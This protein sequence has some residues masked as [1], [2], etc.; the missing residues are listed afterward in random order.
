MAIIEAYAVP[1][2]PI[3]VA[4]VGR[5]QEQEA[6]S[7]LDAF[8]A[9]ARRIAALE[10]ELLIVST[11]HG[12]LYRDALTVSSGAGAWGDLGDFRCP[13]ERIDLRFDEDFVAALLTDAERSGLS[14]IARPVP[15]GALDH[16]VTVP[17]HFVGADLPKG[18]KAVRIGI[19]FEDERAHYE[20]GRCVARVAEATGR[21]TVYLASGDLSHRLKSDGPYGY[22]PSGPAF[23]K[24]MCA[25]FSSGDLDALMHFDAGFRED[26]AE[27]GLNS[28]IIMAGALGALEHGLAESELLSYE[29]PWGV[30][31]GI[32]RFVP[33]RR[34]G[35]GAGRGPATEA[36]ATEGAGARAAGET[37][38]D[39]CPPAGD[40]TQEHRSPSL[41]VRLA[42]A[43]LDDV[44]AGHRRPGEDTP[45]VA[46]LLTEAAATGD[47]LLAELRGRRAGAFVSFHVR[48]VLDPDAE[49][50]LRGCIGTIAATRT[51]LVEEICNNTVSA[52]QHDPRFSPI[53]PRERDRLTCSVDILGETE[54]VANEGELDVKRYGVIVSKGLR[55]GLLLPDLEGVDTPAEQVAIAARKGDIA[56]SED[57]RLERFGVVRYR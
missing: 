56:P 16:G 29:G 1:H 10:P 38:R 19:S 6:H 51:N 53:G 52:A 8:A 31:Y 45:T 54:P 48:N 20:M 9:V 22:N 2:P 39:P 25:A 24:A 46:A 27:C 44:L 14:L 36:G 26:A 47:P 15:R 12:Q 49:G 4:G 18:C 37:D 7:T 41:P 30:G 13:E 40:T 55:R 21:R 43:A 3:L 33:L 42:F 57:Y 35:D 32:A 17:L 5:G 23:D 11:S 34:C 50:D 28:F